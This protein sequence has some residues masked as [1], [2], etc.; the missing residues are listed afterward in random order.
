MSKLFILFF[1]ISANVVAQQN[2]FNVPSSEI[3]P[4]K[5]QFFQHQLNFSNA[6]LISSTTYNYGLGNEFEIGFNLLGLTLD[7]YQTLTFNTDSIPYYPFFCF[8]GQKKLPL[9]AL[10]SI[11]FGAQIGLTGTKEAK[12]G[13]YNYL[14]YIYNHE[15]R[16][17]KI[18]LGLYAVS[19]SF[20]GEGS[21][22]YI[23]SQ[24]INKVGFQLGIEKKITDKLLFQADFISG[25]HA[26]SE[27]VVGFAGNLTKHW[28]ISLGYQVSSFNKTVP[29]AVVFEFTYLPNTK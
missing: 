26:L 8:N 13:Y 9:T 18:I 20:V 24:N 21:R 22:N 14:N 11:A 15:A 3:T 7:Q 5:K 4:K 12:F 27:S 2:F 23:Q 16:K 28:V 25:E 1:F 17:L 19:N 6:A 29:N 10:S